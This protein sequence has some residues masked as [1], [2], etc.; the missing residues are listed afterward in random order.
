MSFTTGAL[1][2][3][4]VIR[5]SSAACNIG[6]ALMTGVVEGKMVS[7]TLKTCFRINRVWNKAIFARKANRAI[8]TG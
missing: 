5:A 7:G 4:T 8:G 6:F 3:T 2:Y 1:Q